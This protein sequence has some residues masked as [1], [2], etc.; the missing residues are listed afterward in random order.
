MGNIH[1]HQLK[2]GD[3]L[4]AEVDPVSFRLRSAPGAGGVRALGP[5]VRE[6]EGRSGLTIDA[7]E[8][9]RYLGL[10]LQSPIQS[11]TINLVSTKSGAVHYL[12]AG[13]GGR[14]DVIMCA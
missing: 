9:G 1:L 11:V 12:A 13:A 8:G 5:S 6:I 2:G 4:P 7:R 10:P 3:T 14:F